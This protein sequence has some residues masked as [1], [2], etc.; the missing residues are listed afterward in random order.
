M[1]SKG[2]GEIRKKVLCEIEGQQYENSKKSIAHAY[3]EYNLESVNSS[4][5]EFSRISGICSCKSYNNF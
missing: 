3:S 2:K 5:V 4:F 1:T